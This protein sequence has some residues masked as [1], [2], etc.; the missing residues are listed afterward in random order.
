MNNAFQFKPLT[1]SDFTLVHHWFNESHVQDFYSLRSW[2]IDEVEKKLM[3]YLDP[4][5]S[6]KPYIVYL[7]KRPIG[8]IQYSS[9]SY[10]PWPDQD[11]SEE[12]VKKGAGIDVFI[13]EKHDIG[14]GIG[15][16]LI[17]ACLEQLI[18]PRFHYCVADPDVRNLRSIRLFEKCGFNI[19]KCI[20]TQDA[21]GRNVTLQLMIKEKLI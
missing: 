2:T 3:P 13:G 8:F 12:I 6:V 19:H 16:S 20:Q 9:L 15:V 1:I 10:N 11:F 14:R 18:W 7:E 5:S 21:L 4:T 17:E